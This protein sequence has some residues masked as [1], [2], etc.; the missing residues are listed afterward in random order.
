MCTERSLLKG[1]LHLQ[2]SGTHARNM[3]K[4]SQGQ[5]YPRCGICHMRKKDFVTL[6]FDDGGGWGNKTVC[7]ECLPMA[8]R[9]GKKNGEHRTG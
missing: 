4:D 5:I 1:R 8:M 7:T 3:A 2:D 6:G 9:K